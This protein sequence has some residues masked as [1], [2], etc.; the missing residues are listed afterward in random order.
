MYEWVEEA[1]FEDI[2]K[3]E[4]FGPHTEAA[5]S[6]TG[7]LRDL[8]KPSISRVRLL[9]RIWNVG[10]PLHF[11]YVIPAFLLKHPKQA[12]LYCECPD[13]GILTSGASARLG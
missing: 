8:T 4:W 6:P 1:I 13:A 3:L 9:H 2:A 7:W 10:N 11:T 12:L 5:P